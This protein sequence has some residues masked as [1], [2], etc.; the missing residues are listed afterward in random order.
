MGAKYDLMSSKKYNE[1]PGPGAYNLS[2]NQKNGV[3]IGTAKR[4]GIDGKE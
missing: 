4:T 1:E 2:D 3:K